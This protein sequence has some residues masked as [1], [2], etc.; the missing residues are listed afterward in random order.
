[1][2]KS[3]ASGCVV[4]LLLMALVGCEKKNGD[5]IVIGKDR[6]KGIQEGPGGPFL[7]PATRRKQPVRS[8][9]TRLNGSD[10]LGRRSRA[11]D[12]QESGA[13]FW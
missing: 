7:H 13:L 1:M 2:K 6:D 9:S 8:F 5:A 12:E 4:A 3:I 10:W 11:P